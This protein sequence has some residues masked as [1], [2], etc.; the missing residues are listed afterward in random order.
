MPQSMNSTRT[1]PLHKTRSKVRTASLVVLVI[2]MVAAACGG[3]WWRIAV[4]RYWDELELAE[5][6]YSE[7]NYSLAYRRLS[8]LEVSWPGE[9]EVIFRLG[10]CELARGRREQALEAWGRV[11]V[12]SPFRRRAL[13][14]CG[15]QLINMGRFA[16]A[17]VALESAMTGA[18]QTRTS[19]AVSWAGSTGS[20][21]GQTTCAGCSVSCGRA[22]DPTLIL[23]ELWSLDTVPWAMDAWALVLAKGEPNDDRIWL[24]RATTWPAWRRKPGSE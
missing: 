24:G 6:D 23:K 21:G 22:P 10:I 17:E 7:G 11:P 20:R 4:R 2:V 8:A 15:Q 16:P 3:V 1:K 18:G 19:S 5:Q 12:E 13:A 9:G 14:L